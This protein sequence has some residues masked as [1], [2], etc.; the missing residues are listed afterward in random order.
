MADTFF[1]KL[2]RNQ[3]F[4]K[5]SGRVEVHALLNP[6]SNHKNFIPIYGSA[7][8]TPCVIDNS[9]MKYVVFAEKCYHIKT[10]NFI[11]SFNIDGDKNFFTYFPFP[12]EYIMSKLNKKEKT[13]LTRL[14][15]ECQNQEVR[16]FQVLVK[17]EK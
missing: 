15:N 8:I 10:F 2:H 11:P 3:N 13:E 4:N 16:F 1:V 7:A 14:L 6:Q 9:L 12:H 5:E 17:N